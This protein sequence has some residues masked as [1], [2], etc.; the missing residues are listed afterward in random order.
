[1][2]RKLVEIALGNRILVAVCAVLL[3]FVGLAAF[4]R[5]PIEAYPNPVPP[6]VEVIAQPPGWSAEET[7]RYVT[8]PLEIGLSGMTGLD[9]IRSQSLFGLTDVKCYFNWGTDYWAARQEVINRLQFIQLPQGITAQLSPWNAIGE[10]FRYNLRGKGYSL[11]DLKTAE[12]WILERQWR[13]VPGVIDVTSFGGLSKEYHVEV[14]PY[15][16]RAR[17]VTLTQLSAALANANQNV[18]GQRVTIG[19]QA[20]TIRGVGLMGSLRDIEDVVILEQKGIPVRVRD[21]ARV[22]IGAAPRLGIVG[23]DGD[24]DVVQGTILMKY[25]GETAATLEGIW[26]RIDY[27]RKNHLLPPGMEIEP[28]YDRGTLTKITTHTVLENLVIG[29]GL[30]TLVLILFLGNLRAALITAVNIPLALLVAFIGMVATG[31]SANL[32]SLGAV[33]FGI[34]VDSTVIMM[35]NIFRHL[36][37]RGRVPPS[38]RVLA[39]ASEVGRPMA[40]STVIIGVAFLPLFTLTGV[41]GVIFAPMSH[42]YALSIGGAIVLALTLTPSLAS[43]FFRGADPG[44]QKAPAGGLRRFFA[45]RI[46]ADEEQ[47]NLIMRFLHRLYNPISEAALQ[48]PKLASL[49]GLVPILACVALFPLLG[50]EFMPKLEEGNFWIRATLPTSVSLQVSAQHV[51]RMRQIL[52]SHPEI[53][54][55]TSQTGRPDDGTD[56][57]GFHNLEFFAPLKPFDEWPAGLTKEKLTEQLQ[58]ELQRE[59]PGVVFNFSQYISDNVEEALSG[60]KGENSVKI[61]GPDIRSNDSIA[62]DVVATMSKVRGV[63]DL[64]LFR[65]MGQPSIKILPDRIQC[66]RYGLNTGD[67]EAVV[68]AAIGGQAVTQVFE[69][70]KS[71][72]LTVRWLPQYRSDIAA[73]RRITVSS[74]DGSQIPLSQIATITAEDSPTVVY[75]EDGRRYTPVKFSVRG[76]DLSSTI[77]ESLERIGNAVRQ[78]PE[79]NLVWAGEI[80]E[81]KEAEGRLLVIVPLTLLIIGFLVYSAV[82][83]WVDTVIV[84]VNIP[85]A[86]SGGILALLAT[87][88]NL[89]V[90]AAMGFIS[91]FGIAVQ[92]AL[93]MVTYFQERYVSGL[94]YV[95]AARQAAE[96]RFRPKLMT[97]LVAMLGLLPA[98]LSHGIGSQTQRPLAIVVIGGS[99][100]LAVL[101]RILQPPF[102]V[103]A[104]RRFPYPEATSLVRPLPKARAGDVVALVEQLDARGGE[105]EIASLTSDTGPG[106]GVPAAV[107]SAAE[108]LGLVEAKRKSLV[109]SLDGHR[110]AKAGGAKRR[111]LWCTRLGELQLFRYVTNALAREEQ[112][113]LRRDFV[114]E[115]IALHMP[116]ENYEAVF[117][118]L[119][120]WSRYG[121]LFDYDEETK[122]IGSQ[123]QPA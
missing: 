40:F 113:R 29:M 33:D 20:Y 11:I 69:G 18:G 83:N 3:L 111:E 63:E 37:E 95:Q 50:K 58:Q 101:T 4:H 115:F 13:Q 19:Q 112:H 94:S 44:A 54:T 23:R 51:S 49:V 116:R 2:V 88:E 8:I 84:L 102:L 9:H 93:L 61:T 28:F 68:Q 97:T 77:Q 47:S 60:V 109:L 99:F 89:S 12:D 122:T 52:R 66:N 78:T 70:E 34:V 41:S 80:N 76:R 92:D 55:V 105:A 38:Q 73:I 98:A 91:I 74:P 39:A 81:L 25:G 36:G 106:L 107:I 42:T 14:D 17:G 121:K 48:R 86:C 56:V 117:D 75:R 67:V 65:S 22:S 31:T 43:W 21:V 32:I 24:D 30:V 62:D 59:Y 90:S 10:V 46:E 108:L 15:Q 45:A 79:T 87:G 71:F 104:H 64:G 16:L 27:I 6:L 26:R 118:T 1:M 7:E 35:E 103:M 123:L 5:L 110:F 96:K 119:I 114:L 72:A 57:T 85:L 120:D 53:L 82:S 100:V